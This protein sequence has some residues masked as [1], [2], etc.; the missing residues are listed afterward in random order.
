MRV[1]S[2]ISKLASI[3]SLVQLLYSSS[4]IPLVEVCLIPDDYVGEK[5]H[6]D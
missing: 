6:L 4:R 2:E 3:A 5:E 1:F